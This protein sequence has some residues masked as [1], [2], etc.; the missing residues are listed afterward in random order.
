[1]K[2]HAYSALACAAALAG[3]GAPAVHY[4][5]LASSAAFED[6]SRTRADFA[7]DV[8]PVSVPPSLDQAYLAIR[9]GQTEIAFLDDERWASPLG[10][11]IRAAVS[12][13]LASRLNTSDVTG[14]S[15]SSGKP[16]AT[17]KLDVRQ[18]DLWPGSRV[19]LTAGWRIS[20]SDRKGRVLSCVTQLE[21][22][23]SAQD[24]GGLVRAQRA[25]V[26]KL[27]DII[28]ENAVAFERATDGRC[29]DMPGDAVMA[30]ESSG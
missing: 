3:C 24:Y 18:F 29:A 28:G 15:T 30:H 17:V 13:R 7:L 6:A 8:M 1:M 26:L 19:Q 4:H 27:A 14:L 9:K 10:N 16:V 20:F 23:V 11:E 2:C 12:A 21:Q 25:V 5:T 22:R